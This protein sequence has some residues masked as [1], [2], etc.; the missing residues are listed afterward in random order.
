VHGVSEAKHIEM[1]T[2]KA[3]S[4]EV[5]IVIAKLKKCHPPGGG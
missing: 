1:R 4:V 2:V 3:S 5:K